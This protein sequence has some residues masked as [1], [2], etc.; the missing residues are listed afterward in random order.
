MGLVTHFEDLMIWQLA[1]S[2]S[3]EIYGVMR[4]NT[5]YGFKDQ[6]QR[7][8]VSVMNNISE[9]FERNSNKEFKRFLDISKGSCGEV[10]GMLYLAEDF[11]YL[12]KSKAEKLRED[13]KALAGSIVNM[14]KS[15][16]E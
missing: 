12:E 11:K 7:A 16:R 4:G 13:C 3:N 14:K 6:I 15:L 9:G 2:L 1:R 8:A 5:D 10:R